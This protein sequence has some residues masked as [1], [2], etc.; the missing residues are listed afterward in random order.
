MFTNNRSRIAAGG[1]KSI[2][3]SLFHERN[4][5]TDMFHICLHRSAQMDPCK[6]QTYRDLDS[7]TNGPAGKLQTP[8][9]GS[10]STNKIIIRKVC[11]KV[12]SENSTLPHCTYKIL[13]ALLFH[14]VNCPS[15]L[16]PL[17]VS[18]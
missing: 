5:R 18:H 11:Q 15:A 1:T 12:S 13:P 10:S 9:L 6:W 17:A 16:E 7:K 8:Y 2:G 3:L 4:R 14:W